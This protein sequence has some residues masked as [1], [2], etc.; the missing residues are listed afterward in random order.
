IITARWI[1]STDDEQ[2]NKFKLKY[3]ANLA[4]DSGNQLT[5]IAPSIVNLNIVISRYPKIMFSKIRE[6]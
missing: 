3:T 1:S 6:H 4:I 2:L 5:Y